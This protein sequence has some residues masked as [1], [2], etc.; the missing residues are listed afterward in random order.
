MRQS[1]LL[2]TWLL[3]SLV[4]TLVLLPVSAFA[5]SDENSGHGEKDKHAKQIVGYFIEWGVYARQYFVKNIVSSGSASKLTTI[6]YAFGNVTNNQCAIADSWADYDMFYDA[7]NSV[8]GVSDTWDAGALRG[9]FNQLKK[10]KALYP[11]IKV[12]ISLGGWTLSGGFS[13]AAQPANVSNFVKSCI[14]LFITDPRWAG[15]FDG[16][17]IDWEYPAACGLQ[18]G[19]PEDTRNFTG[20]LAEFRKQLDTVRPGCC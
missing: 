20:M 3:L 7:S 9:N 16:I 12:V 6:N 14:S 18:C 2:A 11:N 8:D 19:V 5:D 1:K 10:L 17:D 4:A 13:S 15:V